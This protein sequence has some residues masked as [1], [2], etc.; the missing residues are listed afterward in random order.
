MQPENRKIGKKQKNRGANGNPNWANE[1]SSTY[2]ATGEKEEECDVCSSRENVGQKLAQINP[3]KP[4][5]RCSV[6]DAADED[7]DE[8]QRPRTAATKFSAFSASVLFRFRKL[9]NGEKSRV[10]ALRWDEEASAE[11]REKEKQI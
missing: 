3:W 6:P 5:N 7:E 4:P 11:N 9:D 8:L 2:A 10:C 1:M